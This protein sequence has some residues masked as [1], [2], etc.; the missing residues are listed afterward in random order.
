[1]AVAQAKVLPFE[2]ASTRDIDPPPFVYMSVARQIQALCAA[3]HDERG[4]VVTKGP[5]GLGK[6]WALRRFSDE[7]ENAIVVKVD[8]GSSKRGATAIGTMQLIVEALRK[9]YE[10]DTR[11]YSLS[12]AYWTMRKMVHDTI[13]DHFPCMN[14]WEDARLT[15]IFDE[16]QYLSREAVEMLRYWND[17]EDS[18][19]PFPVGLV[20]VGNDEFSLQEDASGYSAISGAVRSRAMFLESLS[21]ADVSNEDL[22]LLLQ[23]RGI[24]DVGAI[25]DF[26]RF[27][28]DTRVPRDLRAIEH[29][30]KRIKR[31]AAGDPITATTV[32]EV[33][34]I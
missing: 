19:T 29:R 24:S 3:A 17:E 11:R 32:R 9:R 13:V 6:T 8:P 14:D 7:H 33:L 28:C 22:A 15:L 27:H 12:N 21:Y 25:T 16:A 2:I 1:M 26:T 31:R 10:G 5:P 20:F 34:A 30:I 23:S 4:I 18:A